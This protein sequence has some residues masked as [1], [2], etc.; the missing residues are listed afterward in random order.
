MAKFERA[1]SKEQKQVRAEEII[2]AAKRIFKKNG[3]EGITLAAIAKEA[4][5]TRSNIY[6]Y[7]KSREEIILQIIV[8]DMEVWV[9]D[10]DKAIA[11]R[12]WTID[13]FAAKW[14]ETI[15]RHPRLMA[16]MSA[17][18]LFLGKNASAEKTLA[19]VTRIKTCLEAMSEILTQS[20]PGLDKDQALKF[21]NLQIAMICGTYPMTSSGSQLTEA[22][23]AVDMPLPC[24]I[25]K[26]NITDSAIYI[27]SGML[28]E[29]PKP[30]KSK[31]K[32]G[33]TFSLSAKS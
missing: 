4:E 32:H 24:D 21:I 2:S 30:E 23:K 10:V 25:V 12:A 14:H 3:L 5:F 6:K 9:R 7:F 11:G 31:N 29:S 1:R 13:E 17:E 26:T 19:F 18:Y 8:G 27:L 16:L 15:A 20:F 22:L 28:G 33:A